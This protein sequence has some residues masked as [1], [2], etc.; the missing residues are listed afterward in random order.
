M[1]SDT[2][3]TFNVPDAID[4]TL[5]VG[6]GDELLHLI[7]DAF[8]ARV[9]VRSNAVTLSG[10]H[11]EVQVLT[12][13]FN[14][15]IKYIEAG[16]VPDQAY[17]RNSIDLLRSGDYAPSAL[18]DDILLTYRGRALRPK[19]AG[20]KTY[21]DAIRKNT[22]TLGLLAQARPTLPWPWLWRRSSAKKSGASFLRAL[23]LKR[24]RAWVFFLAP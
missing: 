2:N 14:E 4:M 7:E 8:D 6:S 23:S 21:V 13:L 16:G 20:Q 12:T 1:T 5:V 3:I 9:T 10:S 17:V 24:G 11:D 19:T 15:L 18:R 22:I